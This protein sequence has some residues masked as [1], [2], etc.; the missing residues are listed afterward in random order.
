MISC[1]GKLKKEK[2]PDHPYCPHPGYTLK[3][4]IKLYVEIPEEDID[5]MARILRRCFRL[6]PAKRA[7]ALE[8]LED[9]FWHGVE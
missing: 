9:P 4:P 2:S 3:D 1:A 6:D 8:L 7:T 5:A